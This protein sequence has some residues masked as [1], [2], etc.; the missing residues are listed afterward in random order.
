M[1]SL[2]FSLCVSAFARD[3]AVVLI[4]DSIPE[5]QETAQSFVDSYQGQVQVFHLEGNKVKQ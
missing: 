3:A 5:Y 1:L 2:F 4:S